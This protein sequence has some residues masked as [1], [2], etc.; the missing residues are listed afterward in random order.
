MGLVGRVGRVGLTVV[1]DRVGPLDPVLGNPRRL[2][3]AV[4]AVEAVQRTGQRP[5]VEKC[6]GSIAGPVQ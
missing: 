3:E 5:D 6:M 4:E 2:L 1:L